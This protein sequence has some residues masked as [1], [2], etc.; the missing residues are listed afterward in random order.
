MTASLPPARLRLSAPT[1]RALRRIGI[2]AAILGLALG[3]QTLTLHATT[4]PFADVRVYY[5]AGARLN[6][7][8]P[9]YDA[10]A[11]DSIG[12]YLNPP[13][14]AILFR[15]LALLPFPAAAAIWQVVI[16]GALVLAIRRA[17]LREPVVLALGWLALPILWALT[18]GQA[19]PI[20]TVL[21]TWGSPASVA[22]AGH[23][24]LVPWLAAGYW[25]VRRDLRA[26]GWFGGWVV[27]LLL[28]QLV[29]APAATLDFLRLTWLRPAFDVRNISPFAIHPALWVAM[30]GGLSLLLVRYRHTAA[31][32]PLA[33][34]L[35]VLSY[36]RLL[37]YQLMSLLAAFGG[38]REA[39]VGTSLD[40]SAVPVTERTT[41]P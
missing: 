40:G 9:L 31:A 29:L 22:I 33:A 15:P 2:V 38:P 3:V 17:G 19:E 5:D 23:L 18:I 25:A 30:V 8:L 32:W 20:L 39:A 21:L 37:V 24:K 35:A 36:P 4:D 41:A 28:V 12:L 13:L 34:G 14:L 7:G 10:T 27:A 11:E 26:L 6:A 16:I 1:V